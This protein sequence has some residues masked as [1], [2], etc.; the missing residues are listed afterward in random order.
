MFTDLKNTQLSIFEQLAK[1]AVAPH[2]AEDTSFGVYKNMHTTNVRPH[3]V[4]RQHLIQPSQTRQFPSRKRSRDAD[5]DEESDIIHKRAR[6]NIVGSVLTATGYVSL[7]A[8]AT[9]ISTLR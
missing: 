7:G 6:R 8:A 5:D 9:W 3:S 2:I 1:N 4:W